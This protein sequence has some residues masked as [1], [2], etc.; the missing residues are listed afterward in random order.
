MV[1]S[2]STPKERI[3]GLDKN[4]NDKYNDHFSNESKNRKSSAHIRVG[5]LRNPPDDK[6]NDFF[7]YSKT[8]NVKGH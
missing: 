6:S 1:V 2:K 3:I 8:E 5:R 4:S 7:E